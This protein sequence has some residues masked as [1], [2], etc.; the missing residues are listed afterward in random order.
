MPKCISPSFLLAA[1]ASVVLAACSGGSAP[2]TNFQPVQQIPPPPPPPPPP[3]SSG[4][5]TLSGTLSFE[6]VPLSAATNGLD[7]DNS[8]SEP[9]RAA[10]VELLDA[11]DAVIG[12]TVADAQGRYSFDVPADTQVRV[13]VRAAIRA[14]NFNFQVV[15]NT[16]NNALYTLQG[17]LQ[18]VG[19]GANQTRDLFAASGWT[20]SAYTQTRAGAP[21][22]LLDTVYGSIQD[23]LAIDPDINFPRFDILWSVNNRPERGNVADGEIGSSSFTISNGRPVIRIVGQANNDTDE[24]DPHVVTH[25]FGHYIENQLSRSDSIGGPH[26]LGSRLDPRVAFSEGWGNALSAILTGDTIYRDSLGPSQ[27][28]G[29]S[30]DIENNGVRNQGWYSE[31]SVQSILYDIFDSRSDGPDQLSLGLGPLYQTFVNPAYLQTEAAATIFS[32]ADNFLRLNNNVDPNILSNMLDNEQIFGRG[33][34][35]AGEINDGG[36]ST[37]LPVYRPVRSGGAPLT[38]CSVNN[39]GLF[40]RLGNRVFLTFDVANSGRFNFRMQRT[41]GPT[42]RDPDFRIFDR[43]RVIAGGISPDADLETASIQLS[44]GRYVIS[45]LDDRNARI[46]DEDEIGADSCYSF[47]IS[48]G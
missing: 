14:A 37:S 23:F 7:Y 1:A 40:N 35:G 8:F 4:N 34:E 15:D 41:S 17:G 43:G 46:N 32:Y 45:A 3:P 48:G 33:T 6:R 13:R 11:A 29:F 36:L 21:F 39:F 9:I 47:S 22:A 31:A 38:L 26:S 25:E 19:G 20:G 12:Q 28:S 16:S 27:S 42:G 44:A 24:Y 10:E 5:V 2:Q 30:F 18:S